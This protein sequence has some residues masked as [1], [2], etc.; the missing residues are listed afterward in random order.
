MHRCKDGFWTKPFEYSFFKGTDSG[1]TTVI[2]GKMCYLWQAGP[3]GTPL[4]AELDLLLGNVWRLLP[5]TQYPCGRRPAALPL[6]PPRTD[7][8]LAV[9]G[10]Q[11]SLLL[12]YLDNF[13][14]TFVT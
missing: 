14:L 5:R 9:A 13:I 4:S 7:A 10:A 1:R 12:S 8:A 2:Y 6:L 11:C 3:G